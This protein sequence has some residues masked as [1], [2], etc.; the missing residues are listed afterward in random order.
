MPSTWARTRVSNRHAEVQVVKVYSSHS[1]KASPRLCC[2]SRNS[3]ND[4]DAAG[5][6][7]WV[8]RESPRGR[9]VAGEWRAQQSRCSANQVF[10]VTLRCR[11]RNVALCLAS[12]RLAIIPCSFLLCFSHSP[13]YGLPD[14]P[15]Y[16][17]YP[18]LG[19]VLV[20]A[21]IVPSR[22]YRS[23][24][25]CTF[26]WE[27]HEASTHDLGWQRHWRGGIGSCLARVLGTEAPQKTSADSPGDFD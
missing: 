4:K 15:N 22:H 26:P 7:A 1:S 11:L 23:E 8:A 12:G 20:V 2:G 10:A 17:V 16:S 5:R 13:L 24:S 27:A 21:T 14:N 19:F 6:A 25:I 9:D 3:S 18:A